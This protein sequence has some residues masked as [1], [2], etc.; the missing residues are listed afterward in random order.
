MKFKN[1]NDSSFIISIDGSVSFGENEND[2][3]Y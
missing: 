1:E 2:S 3:D